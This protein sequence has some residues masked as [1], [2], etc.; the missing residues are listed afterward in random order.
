MKDREIKNEHQDELAEMQR[1]WTFDVEKTSL[2]DLKSRVR[3]E[4]ESRRK[5]RRPRLLLVA[6]LWTIGLLLMATYQQYL[7]GNFV[8][9]ALGLLLLILAAWLGTSSSGP[10]PLS[11]RPEDYVRSRLRKKTR[12]LRRTRSAQLIAVLVLTISL[13]SLFFAEKAHLD[14]GSLQ[15][16]IL[17]LGVLLLA[18][19]TIGGLITV[20]G[21]KRKE[22][23]YLCEL[24]KQFESLDERTADPAP[25]SA[26][27]CDE[28]DHSK[29]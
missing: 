1:D 7:R 4:I 23:D 20:R 5:S 9:L 29:K 21:S 14:S 8:F 6:S 27:G 11:A 10:G 25:N 13:W 24:Q 17:P 18:L 15:D 3:V 26:I 28:I 22:L 19:T 2:S 16:K 12:E